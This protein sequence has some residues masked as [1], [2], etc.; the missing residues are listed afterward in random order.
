MGCLQS[1]DAAPAAPGTASGLAIA[2]P[3][4]GTSTQANAAPEGP[5]AAADPSAVELEEQAEARDSVGNLPSSIHGSASDLG[6]V[7]TPSPRGGERRAVAFGDVQT[8]DVPTSPPAVEEHSHFLLQKSLPQVPAANVE[9]ETRAAGLKHIGFGPL[10]KENQDEYFCQVGGFGGQKDGSCYCI[11]D[12]HGNYGRDAAH[13]CR[14]ELPVLFDAELR[15]YYERAAAE[16]VKDPS[17]K[18]LIEPILSDAFVETERRLHQAGINVSSSGTTASVIFQNRASVWVAAAGDSRVLCIA[19]LDNQWKVQPLTLDHRPSRKTEKFR[20]EAAGGRV[21]PKRLPSGKTVG[22]PRLWLA[23]LPSPGLLL[24]RS[25]GDDMAT[26]VGCTAR[27]EV[28]FMALRPFL[29]QYLVIA[30]DGVWDVLSNDT[31]AQLVGDA[32]DPEAA[33]QAVLEAALLEWEERLAADNISIIVVQLVWGDLLNSHGSNAIFRMAGGSHTGHAR[34]LLSGA[35]AASV[36]SNGSGGSPI[37]DEA[38]LTH[39]QAPPP[40]MTQPPALAATASAAADPG[41]GPAAPEAL[42]SKGT[43]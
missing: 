12:G 20:V 32:A 41:P 31:V 9:L 5:P 13:F 28:T 39:T 36:A 23:H 15:R 8:F 17:A 2:A 33:C 26:S 1:K 29:D 25:I 38:K 40:A 7:V 43:S 21:E 35:S 10:K 24:S 18:E 37:V 4:N 42:P 27:P 14:Q 3:T 16:G 34:R 19:Q 6:G 11:F 22:E 30:S